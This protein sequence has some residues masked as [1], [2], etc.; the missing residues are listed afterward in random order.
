MKKTRRRYTIS[1]LAQMF[2]TTSRTIRYYEE[3]GLLHPERFGSRRMY[4]ER[5]RV[6]LK[7]ILRGR[8]LGFSLDEIREMLDL[9]DTDPTEVHQLREVVRRG[10]EKIAEIEAQI[11]DLEAVRNELQ[12]LVERLYQSLNEKMDRGEVS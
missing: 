11:R 12:D 7:L 5:D 4:S 6:R 1:E 2:D 3:V 10:K 9:Y 8:R